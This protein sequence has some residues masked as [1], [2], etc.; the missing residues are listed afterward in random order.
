MAIA[1]AQTRAGSYFDPMTHP[2][3]GQFSPR[4]CQLITPTQLRTQNEHGVESMDGYVSYRLLDAETMRSSDAFP[5]S[6]LAHGSWERLGS[7]FVKST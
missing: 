3:A 1:K 5:C 7:A 4:R 6:H 2:R